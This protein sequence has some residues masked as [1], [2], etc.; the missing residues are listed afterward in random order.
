MR[1]TK[2]FYA[3][4][5]AYLILFLFGCEYSEKARESLGLDELSDSASDPG[6]SDIDRKA[7][8]TYSAPP[9]DSPIPSPVAGDADSALGN[10]GGG[11]GGGGGGLVT[12][13][14]GSVSGLAMSS[15]ISL[16]SAE[17][18]EN[19]NQGASSG[20]RRKGNQA[21]AFN[22]PNTDYSSTK[23]RFHVEMEALE[24]LSMANFIMC[25][26]KQLAPS[27]VST[28]NQGPYL[29][30]VN[31]SECEKGANADN[32]AQTGSSGDSKAMR[33]QSVVVDSSRAS[34]TANQVVKVWVLGNEEEPFE[35]RAEAVV[36][37]GVSAANPFG[38]FELSW[39]E[40][41][42][43]ENSFYGQGSLSTFT[44]DP[45]T[46]LALPDDGLG[47]RFFT[48]EAL[49]QRGPGDFDFDTIFGNDARFIRAASAIMVPDS[50]GNLT[51]GNAFTQMKIVNG[52][53]DDVDIEDRLTEIGGIDIEE[54]GIDNFSR[55]FAISY[56]SDNML[57]QRAP[58]YSELPINDS[59]NPDLT[60]GTCFS[61]TQFDQAVWC[62]ELFDAD[63]GE[64]L[65]FEPGF[66][67]SYEKENCPL[68]DAYGYLGYWGIWY[69][70]EH[71]ENANCHLESGDIIER[72][73]YN[74]NEN[75]QDYE[76]LKSPGK[77]TR[78]SVKSL[79]LANLRGVEMEMWQLPGDHSSF[80]EYDPGS[81]PYLELRDLRNDPGH[82][83]N[84]W[85]VN[86]LTI[87]NDAAP[88]DGFYVI[89][90]KTYGNHGPSLTLLSEIVDP[91]GI[92]ALYDVTPSRFDG[93]QL[94][95]YSSQLG[96][97][98]RYTRGDNGIT[99]NLRETV[100]PNDEIFDETSSLD[101]NCLFQCPKGNLVEADLQS[102]DGPY[103]NWDSNGINPVAYTFTR[104]DMLLKNGANQSISLQAGNSSNSHYLWGLN[105]G[106]MVT[107]DVLAGLNDWWDV[108]N[109]EGS[110]FYTWETG[111]NNWNQSIF[112]KSLAT[113][114]FASF[115]KPIE[116]SYSHET[117]NDR[118]ESNRFDGKT[119][120]L[121]YGGKCN[122][123][124]IP[125]EQV[126]VNEGRGRWYPAFGL[127]DG[128][129]LGDN[130]D[131]VV[132]AIEG[133]QMPK[134][135][136][137]Q[138][139]ALTIEQPPLGLPNQAVGSPSHIANPSPN[140]SGQAPLVI[141]G[142]VQE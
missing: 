56:D 30:L 36:K 52:S 32:S 103:E 127:K 109:Q 96:G 8:D 101:L 64:A 111:T 4:L 122:L 38:V 131:Y 105:S 2:N 124:G 77:L 21:S 63:S 91:V 47:L 92:D 89:G 87:A 35:I 65:D 71:S 70:G 69:E 121:G 132:K 46:N 136:P 1:F 118:R 79:P 28:L 55:T 108:F 130:D 97:D 142:E 94:W 119:F 116:F 138:C 72:K 11:G 83:I 112:A 110:V 45:Q 129:L 114:D 84:N 76:L 59:E 6:T 50:Q 85:V 5:G 27:T 106:P 57:I 102:Y 41:N 24:P 31:E 78:Q 80:G 58:L 66:P 16:L 99:Y 120:L 15:S 104:N 14:L 82:E 54:F 93:E 40:V 13:N 25:F 107:D 140:L 18:S 128:T 88:A 90:Y 48:S 115:D 7:K 49:R 135:T 123:W 20:K 51:E 12:P 113:N 33:Y 60:S 86:Y 34:A 75:G 100:S 44:R 139:N 67:F 61:R 95:L 29:A 74:S 43:D 68:Q 37:E 3:I 81:D 62:Y 141:A 125:H 137:G 53:G 26:I 19:N 133:E 134:T 126:G 17:E 73:N 10:S 98:V 42:T 23:S 117:A 9:N 39:V 22:S